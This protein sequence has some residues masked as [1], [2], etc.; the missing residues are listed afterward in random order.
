M[1]ADSLRKE[2]IGMKSHGSFEI[3]LFPSEVDALDH[4]FVTQFREI[5]ED[6]AEQYRCSL[7]AFSIEK[8]TVS[9]AFDNEEIT[10]EI[11]KLLR[12]DGSR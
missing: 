6:L 9:F 7:T 4:P 10:A 1:A 8:G 3:E 2:R 5:L 11:V 12:N